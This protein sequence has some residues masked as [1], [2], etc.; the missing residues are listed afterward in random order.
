MRVAHELKTRVIVWTVNS[1]GTA[2][3]FV[4]LGA[5]ALCTDDVQILAN[6]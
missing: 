4:S 2:E 3:I 1:P 6:L 5:D